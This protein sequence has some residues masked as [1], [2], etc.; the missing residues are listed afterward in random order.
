MM[1]KHGG[2]G[3]GGGGALDLIMVVADG[4]GQLTPHRR[5]HWGE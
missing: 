2:G 4:D 1:K 3:G 5:K